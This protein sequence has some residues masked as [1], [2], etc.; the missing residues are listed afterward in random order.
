MG[1]PNLD[2]DRFWADVAQWS[3]DGRAG[4]WWP[5][6]T[7]RFSIVNPCHRR[8]GRDRLVECPT[9][10][11]CLVSNSDQTPGIRWADGAALYSRFNTILPT[12]RELC[13]AGGD[14]GIGMLLPSSRRPGGLH[15]CMPDGAVRFVTDSI[16]AGSS[17]SGTLIRAGEG[18][19][20]P[21]SQSPYGLWGALGIRAQQEKLE[22]EF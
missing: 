5:D 21:G 10:K 15:L 9:S 6:R 1:G 22:G 8:D 7:I 19:R 17:D 13:L 2:D 14:A 4:V 3:G 16:E 20:A 18:A 11:S 12:N